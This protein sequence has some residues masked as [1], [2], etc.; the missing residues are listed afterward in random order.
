MKYEQFEK[1]LQDDLSWR[2]K[3]IS[4]LYMIC[5]NND[6]EVLLKSIILMLYAHWEGYIKKSSK[7]YIKYIAEKKI[8]IEAL[9]PN[10]KAIALKSHVNKCIENYDKLTLAHE[11]DFMNKYEV[12]ENKKFKIN[13]DPDNDRESDIINTHHNL[14]PKVFKNIINILGLKYNDA[15]K[16]REMYISNNLL[17][18]RNTIGHGSKFDLEN[19]LDF[20]LNINDIDKL[21][22]IIIYI[23]DFHKDT[24]LDYVENEFY[25]SINSDK[26]VLYDEEKDSSLHRRLD[27]IENKYAEGDIC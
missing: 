2:K 23:L 22:S 26:R 5:L 6:N 7:L 18:N 27:E 9:T 3:E 20:E 12:M 16:V 14:K 11:L 21:K 15:Y 10:F 19:Q 1:F 13:I 24:L 4:D 25:L 8:K 17:S